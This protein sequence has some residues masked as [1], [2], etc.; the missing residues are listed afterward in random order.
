MK[1]K[2]TRHIKNK[3]QKQKQID[4]NKE[5]LLICK[6]KTSS[7]ESFEKDFEKGLGQNLTKQNNIIQRELIRLF[8]VPFSPSKYTPRN[9]YYTYINYEWITDQTKQ[10]QNTKKFYVQ[11]DSFRIAQEKVYYELIDITKEYIK[12]NHGTK[13]QSIKDLYNSMLRL[14]EKSADDL[15]APIASK[16]NSKRPK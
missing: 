8:K 4:K 2:R 12:D 9:D 1:T 6:N 11:I 13:A 14:D 15:F 3:T 7:I 10:L 5:L 16:A